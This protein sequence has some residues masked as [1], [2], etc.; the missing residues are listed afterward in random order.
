MICKRNAKSNPKPTVV[1]S[2]ATDFK[3][4]EAIDLKI[5]GNENILW[6]VCV[7]KRFIKGVVIK[8]KILETII[9]GIHEAWCLDIG[10]PTV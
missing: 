1:I 5:V 2:R 3:S 4:V 7:F 10:F 6:R 9:R 8:D